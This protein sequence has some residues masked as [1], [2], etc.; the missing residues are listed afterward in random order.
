MMAPVKAC[1]WTV[2]MTP[3]LCHPWILKGKAGFTT[4]LSTC[5]EVCPRHRG[6]LGCGEDDRHRGGGHDVIL[7]GAEAHWDT[8]REG[9][10]RDCAQRLIDVQGVDASSQG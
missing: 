5:E 4:T 10:L 9:G 7:E 2:H 8:S 6:H 1:P 3:S